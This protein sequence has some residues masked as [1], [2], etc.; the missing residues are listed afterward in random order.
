MLSSN[1]KASSIMFL[2]SPRVSRQRISFFTLGM[3]H[4]A[5]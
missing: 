1:T 5:C 2:L 4:M 3:H